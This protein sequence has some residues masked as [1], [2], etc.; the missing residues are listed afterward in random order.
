VPAS[1]T[2]KAVKSATLMGVIGDGDGVA[3]VRLGSE[4][5][6]VTRGDRIRG[7][8]RVVIIDVVNSVVI[9]EEDGERFELR[10]G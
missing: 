9:L 7:T 3:I 4:T 1:P 2:A 6:V 10:M 5:F 8:I